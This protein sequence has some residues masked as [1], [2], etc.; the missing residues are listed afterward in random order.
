MCARVDDVEVTRRLQ[1]R[2]GGEEDGFDEG[3]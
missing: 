3:V 1:H 2:G